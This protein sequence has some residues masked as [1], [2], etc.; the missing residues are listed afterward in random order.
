MCVYVCVCVC[1]CVYVC[2]CVC[3]CVYVCICV[4]SYVCVCV[5]AC[6]CVCV[7]VCLFVCVCVCVCMCVCVCVCV[8]ERTRQR[9]IERSCYFSRAFAYL[10][11]GGKPCKSNLNKMLQEHDLILL[12]LLLWHFCMV[13]IRVLV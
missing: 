12:E 10:K 7:C 5:C 3:M 11:F 9:E 13:C 1:M 8:R 2:V 4:R 6:V